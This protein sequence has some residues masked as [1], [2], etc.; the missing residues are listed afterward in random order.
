MK[1]K[2]KKIL[3]I[4][5]ILFSFCFTTIALLSRQE[6]KR[7]DCTA[8]IPI[9]S[10]SVEEALALLSYENKNKPSLP[11]IKPEK[12]AAIVKISKNE[13]TIH[14][15]L[16]IQKITKIKAMQT[17]HSYQYKGNYYIFG[18][19][20]GE[21]YCLEYNLNRTKFENV[22][23]R[24]LN[25]KDLD[26][27]L[28]KSYRVT[29]SDKNI[30]F[31]FLFETFY[32]IILF[33]L[34]YLYFKFIKSKLLF[35]SFVLLLDLISILIIYIYS[36]A[37]FDYDFFH[38]RIFIEN[39]FIICY[40]IIPVIFPLSIITITIYILKKINEYIKKR[41]KK[42]SKIFKISIV[43]VLVVFLASFLLTELTDYIKIKKD[44][45]LIKSEIELK[46]N[47]NIE[48]LKNDDAITKSKK[49]CGNYFNNSKIISS[50]SLHSIKKILGKKNKD[51]CKRILVPIDLNLTDFDNCKYLFLWNNYY[52]NYADTRRI[53]NIIDFKKISRAIKNQKSYKS[54]YFQYLINP[55]IQIDI[56][57]N[58]T[59]NIYAIIIINR[60]IKGCKKGEKKYNFLFFPFN[61]FINFVSG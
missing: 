11:L 18:I 7:S 12:F 26:L 32:L 44:V 15:K 16:T 48:L 2:S 34:F 58:E 59:D 55:Y 13:I 43:I 20:A 53:K 42:G 35:F 9:K 5:V 39:I 10:L 56:L 40:F 36:P 27:Q 52:F 30:P 47:E 1:S 25:K 17:P 33:S 21:L 28:L 19:V 31:Y 8:Y 3:F 41:N 24:K 22:L 38:Q 6:Y 50:N 46:L 45:E 4:A 57:K 54:N 49:T 37:F 29:F 51:Y 23:G 14:S 60:E 61:F